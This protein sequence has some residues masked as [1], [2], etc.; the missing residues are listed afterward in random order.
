[1]RACAGC[2]TLIKK[3]KFCGGCTPSRPVMIAELTLPEIQILKLISEGRTSK[4]IAESEVLDRIKLD[5]QINKLCISLGVSKGGNRRVALTLAY[6]E[7]AA[8]K[9]RLATFSA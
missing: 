4:D 8:E 6:L 5:N 7:Y 2:T 9:N 1:M 3:G